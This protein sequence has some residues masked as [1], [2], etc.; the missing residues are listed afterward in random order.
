MENEYYKIGKSNG[1]LREGLTGHQVCTGEVYRIQLTPEIMRFLIDTFHKSKLFEMK[2][3]YMIKH[4]ELAFYWSVLN[5]EFFT[6]IL[7]RKH[8]GELL[9]DS[10][11]TNEPNKYLWK[12]SGLLH[13]YIP[14]EILKMAKSYE[15][16]SS[17]DI[18]RDNN[19]FDYVNRELKVDQDIDKQ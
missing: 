12:I 10:D 7:F 17:H 11:V 18:T 5:E 6:D 14:H 1:L 15:L 8:N 13:V 19:V 3:A 2:Y 9:M 4:I 16:F